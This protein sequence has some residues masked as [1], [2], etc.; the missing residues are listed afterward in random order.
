MATRW[1]KRSASSSTH[2][3]ATYEADRRNHCGS[4]T[5][6]GQQPRG[7]TGERSAGRSEHFLKARRTAWIG[8]RERT[9]KET[10]ALPSCF[11]VKSFRLLR[12]NLPQTSSPSAQYLEPNPRSQD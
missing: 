9:S 5:V 4:S 10:P 6:T 1:T 8:N 11:R 12:T 3:T 2:T 7:L